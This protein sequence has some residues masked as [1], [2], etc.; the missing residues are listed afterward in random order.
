MFVLDYS[1]SMGVGG[2]IS[3]AIRNIVKVFDKYIRPTDRVGFI[4]F[5][6]NCDVVFSIV[7]KKKN[8]DHLRRQI[9]DST[10]PYGSTA[11]YNSLYEAI[12]LFAKA[13]PKNNSKWI[14][15]LSD[16]DDNESKIEYPQIYK[17]LARS[18]ANLVIVGLALHQAVIPKLKR[19]CSATKD[20]VFI[21]SPTE[22]LDVAFQAMSDIIYGQDLINEM[23]AF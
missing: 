5:N 16:G 14:V 2:R 3:N 23:I 21:E 9:E 20:G 13:E 6:L 4:R 12:K 11:L 1:Q 8:T 15:A 22:D 7:E 17:K 19:L 10:K 18:D